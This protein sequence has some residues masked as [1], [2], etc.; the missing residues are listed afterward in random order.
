MK[1]KLYSIPV[2]D[3]FSGDCE[4]PVCTMFKKL[5]DDAVD[6]TMGPSY[7]EDD[8]RAMTDALGF[9]HKHIKMVYHKDNR[10]GMAW[11]MK[12]HFDKT[13]DEV[14]K[15]LPSGSAKMLKKGIETSPVV[16][17]LDKL[18]NS[19]FVCKRI[20]DFFDRYVDTIFYLWKSDGDFKSRFNSCKGFCNEH[21]VMLLKK[22]VDFLK[23][24]DLEEFINVINELYITN[25]ERVRDD[26]AWFINK[27]DYKY[28]DEP[29]YNAKDSVIR[30]MVKSN[31]V[32]LE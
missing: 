14:R 27:F 30:S 32:I 22:S 26:V 23:G 11:V 31:G 8:T 9:C 29:W 12:T 5:E 28:Q 1:E 18:N 10:L 15:A 6:Y 3:A 13:I 4:C 16:K 2:N 21:Y 20:N 19:C 25:L 7:M 17:Y 24:S